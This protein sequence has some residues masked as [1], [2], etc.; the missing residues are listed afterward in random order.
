MLIIFFVLETDLQLGVP[1][2]LAAAAFNSIDSD[3]SG[4][5]SLEEFTNAFG[6]L[7]GLTKK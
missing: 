4:T 7:L 6:G 5:L 2:F 3:G 1:W